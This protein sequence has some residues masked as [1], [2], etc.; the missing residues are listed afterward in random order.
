MSAHRPTGGDRFAAQWRA[1]AAR[2]AAEGMYRPEDEHDA[3]GVGLIASLDGQPH[4]HVVEAGLQVLIENRRGLDDTAFERE[5]FLV[6]RRIEKAALDAHIT[7]LYL[8]SLSC[9]SVI[10]KGMFLAEQLD[11]FFPDLRDE[12]FVSRFAI[13]HQRY[14]TNTF[15]TWRLAQPFRSIAHNGEINTVRGNREQVRGRAGDQA[16]SEVARALL[17]A[18][19]LL[20][21]DGSDSLSLDEALELL[22]TTGWALTP[23]RTGT[24]R[25]CGE[26]RSCPAH[27][28]GRR[29]S[30][31]APDWSW[32]AW[33]PTVTPRSTMC[34]T[35]IADTRCLSR[36]WSASGRRSSGSPRFRDPLLGLRRMRRSL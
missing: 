26:F 25:W 30:A 17:D 9:R 20:S 15:P 13:S 21:D 6:R 7:E 29:T 14:S 22:T 12:R 36:T 2:L 3:C 24:T 1:E 28:C 16:T 34:S 27:R 11:N 31:Q 33:S 23:A 10:Y 4:R 18:G 19:P 8:C 32:Q 5:L 35:S